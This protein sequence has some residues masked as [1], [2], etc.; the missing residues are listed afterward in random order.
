MWQRS[1]AVTVIVLLLLGSLF[2][3]NSPVKLPWR[4]DKQAQNVN[5]IPAEAPSP[6]A[7]LQE[8]EKSADQTAQPPEPVDLRALAPLMQESDIPN[9]HPNLLFFGWIAASLCAAAILIGLLAADDIS[10]PK[11]AMSH[12]PPYSQ[13]F[14]RR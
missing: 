8:D 6:A 5:A 4:L 9:G 12:S 14:S 10:G 1:A 11:V 2:L 7:R 13:A 3:P